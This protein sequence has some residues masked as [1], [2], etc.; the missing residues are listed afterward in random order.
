MKQ[1]Q[2]SQR[3]LAKGR[4]NTRKEDSDSKF[5]EEQGDNKGKHSDQQ[6]PGTEKGQQM[7][8]MAI[9]ETAGRDI[10]NLAARWR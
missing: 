6:T 1:Q 9:R 2:G 8:D 7:K 4:G 10:R 3:N 5:Y